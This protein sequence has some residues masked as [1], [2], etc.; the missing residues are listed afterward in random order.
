[1]HIPHG[2][3]AGLAYW[4]KLRPPLRSLS[5]SRCGVRGHSPAKETVDNSE[6][7]GNSP[8]RR[9][10]CGGSWLLLHLHRKVLCVVSQGVDAEPETFTHH[11]QW[12]ELRADVQVTRSGWKDQLHKL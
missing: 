4:H 12:V 3:W 1:M 11:W 7:S 6:T 10:A 2:R 9:A 8:F 5:C